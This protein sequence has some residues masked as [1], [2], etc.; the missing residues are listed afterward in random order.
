MEC[1]ITAVKGRRL[2]LV[3]ARRRVVVL[4]IPVSVAVELEESSSFL[5]FNL[6]LIFWDVP[7]QMALDHN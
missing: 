2:L 5:P 4:I 1:D 7:C 3:R 6:T